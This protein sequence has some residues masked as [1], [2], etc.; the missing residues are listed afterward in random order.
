MT[1]YVAVSGIAPPD[2]IAASRA[3][4]RARNRFRARSWKE[5]RLLLAAV[6]IPAASQQGD[7]FVECRSGQVSIGI[8]SG[9]SVDRANP[10]P[11]PEP[12]LPR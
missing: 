7:D 10:R 12:R 9:C 1:A 11:I 3:P 6:R 4:R 2:V 8:G 5:K